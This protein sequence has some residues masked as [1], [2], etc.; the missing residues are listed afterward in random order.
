MKLRTER[1]PGTDTATLRRAYENAKKIY[2]EQVHWSGVSLVEHCLG[3]LE[4]YLPFDPDDEGVVACLMHHALDTQ[5]WAA[6]DIEKEYGAQVRSVV[7]A[8]HLLSHVTTHD[9]RIPLENL[10]TMFLRVAIDPRTLI[11]ILCNEVWKLDRLQD[12]TPELRRRICRDVLQLFS[13]VAARLGM[14]GLKH[15]LESRAF[16]VLY[17]VDATRIAEQLNDIHSRYGDFLATAGGHLKEALAQQGI[18]AS[19]ETREKQIYSIF[20]KMQQKTVTH[21]EDLYD[22]FALRVIVSTEAECYQTLGILHRVGYPVA[23]RFKDYIGFPKPNGYRSLHTTLMRLP[24]APDG[25]LIEVQIRT[26]EMHRQAQ[27]GIAAHWNYKEGG[28]SDFAQRRAELHDALLHHHAGE[29]SARIPLADHI[30]VLTPHG[31][32]IELPE[33]ATPLDFAF[34]VHTDVGLSFKSARVNGSIVPIGHALEN[35]DIVEILRH[36]EPHPTVNW[37]SILKT[38]SARSKLKRYLAL[39][40]REASLQRGREVLNAELARRGLPALDGDLTVLAKHAGSTLN[41]SQRTDLLIRLSQGA[42]T[43]SSLVRQLDLLQSSLISPS[44][45]RPHNKTQLGIVFEDNL[46]MPIRFTRCC[47][48]D[49]QPGCEIEGIAGRDGHVRIHRRTCKMLRNANAERK[50]GVRWGR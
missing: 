28:G 12:V 43:A 10:R 5:L 22:L 38:A 42:M 13:P 17:P 30:F 37:I 31:D 2:G 14:Y 9:R 44:Q 3:V 1:I 7:T 49:L 8:A 27:L 11:L 40:D 25:M 45:S 21:V 46:Q 35:G 29:E 50:V 32:I 33:G 4:L 23:H 18:D 19:I 16:P 34:A 26:Q 20:H 47:K 41:M 39:H 15:R 36:K 48:A 24:G 6:V